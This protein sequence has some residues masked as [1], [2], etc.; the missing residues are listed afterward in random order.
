MLSHKDEFQEQLL[1]QMDMTKEY[2]DKE[3]L[4]L[5]DDMILNES[6]QNPMTLD[7]KDRL[8][9]ELFDSIRKLD[10][11]SELLEN[12]EITEIMVNGF[13]NIFI[14]KEGKI[15]KYG[16]QFSSPERLDDVIQ[17]IVGQCN[18]V[19]NE[20]TPIVDARLDNGSR[21]SIVLKPVAL[22]GPILSI[23][24]FPDSPITML[25]LIQNNSIT[26]E[27]AHFL[28][29]LVISGYSIMIGGGTSSGKT[30]F[31]NAL[32]NFIPSSERVVTIEDNAELQIQNVDN[33]VRLECR[34]GTM[35]ESLTITMDDLIK[36]ALRM[37]PNRVIVG[38]I[39][40]PEARS[41]ISSLNL[42][43]DGSM[44]TAHANSAAE[45]ITRLETMV[46]MG[47]EL[48]LFVVRRQ[49]ASGIDILIHL[50]RDKDGHRQ[51]EEI[52]EVL[53]LQKEDVRLQTL[54]DRK[55]GELKR[56]NDLRNTQKLERSGYETKI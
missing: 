54:Y 1:A 46:L 15:Q 14:E 28:Q 53:D 23:R 16:H 47:M 38:E 37:R 48:P 18:R 32:S 51:V 22:N 12:D 3:V 10:I 49:I 4:S 42:G 19:V 27:A 2:E 25:D 43:H 6:R 26:R 13:Q 33:L 41:Y 44:A 7:E 29:K 36:S 39:R 30:T 20:Q 9:R 34:A 8:R 24:R 17:Q 45:M 52:T 56:R 11:L 31:L 50:G 55:D 5:I 21:V 40:G 35:N